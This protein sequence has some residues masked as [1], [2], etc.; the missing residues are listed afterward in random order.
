MIWCTR[1]IQ[2]RTYFDY[3]P[4]NRRRFQINE[5][6]RKKIPRH[7]ILFFLNRRKIQS[8]IKKV[9]FSFLI[10][11]YDRKT[12]LRVH[13]KKKIGKTKNKKK[14]LSTKS[15]SK[16]LNTDNEDIIK[17]CKKDTNTIGRHFEKQ[18]YKMLMYDSF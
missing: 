13:E 8:S 17:K 3:V 12:K 1:E 14:T 11:F 4:D 18:M 16:R 9:F 2:N 10:S 7:R 5:A 6:E 15:F